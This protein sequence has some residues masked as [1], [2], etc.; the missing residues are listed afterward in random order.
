M[1]TATSKS[2]YLTCVFVHFVHSVYF[3]CFVVYFADVDDCVPDQCQNGGICIDTGRNSFECN[4]TGTGHEGNV[5]ADGKP[6]TLES[7]ST[8]SFAYFKIYDTRKSSF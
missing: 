7:T 5:C 3:S 4:C 1:E 8:Q 2:K 6:Y